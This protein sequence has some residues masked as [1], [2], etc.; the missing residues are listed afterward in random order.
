MSMLPLAVFRRLSLLVVA[1]CT[2]AAASAEA[3]AQPTPGALLER[4]AYM[5]PAALPEKP[6]Y[7][8]TDAGEY[9]RARKDRRFQLT[10]RH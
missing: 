10:G 3:G 7:G 2:A 1:W 9:Q 8:K 6:A 5:L 4:S